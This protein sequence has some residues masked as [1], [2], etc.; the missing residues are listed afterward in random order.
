[1]TWWFWIM[2]ICIWHLEELDEPCCTPRCEVTEALEPDMLAPLAG[3]DGK[4]HTEI[5]VKIVLHQYH[6]KRYN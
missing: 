3:G 4:T 2:C 6:K 5:M 1:M